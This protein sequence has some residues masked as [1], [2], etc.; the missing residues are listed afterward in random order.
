VAEYIIHRHGMFIM[1]ELIKRID[2][3]ELSVTT[4][5]VRP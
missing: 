2:S 1:P 4:C 5:G 3:K